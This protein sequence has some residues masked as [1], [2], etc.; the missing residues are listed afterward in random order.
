MSI[1][2]ERIAHSKAASAWGCQGATGSTRCDEGRGPIVVMPGTFSAVSADG[3]PHCQVTNMQHRRPQ[4]LPRP[5]DLTL[6]RH[7]LLQ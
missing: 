3:V 4:A 2:V 5:C 6:V 7:F 1:G